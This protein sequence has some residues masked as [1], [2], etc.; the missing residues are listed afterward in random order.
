M[1]HALHL[2]DAVFN[3][4]LQQ[5]FARIHVGYR[6]LTLGANSSLHQNALVELL[7]HSLV[8]GV[9]QSPVA[10]PQLLSSQTIVSVR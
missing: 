4:G 5:Y 9:R 3:I 10:S 7:H 2:L 6:P 8:T 1:L